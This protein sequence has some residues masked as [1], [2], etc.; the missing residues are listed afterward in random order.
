MRKKIIALTMACVL[1]SSLAACG[2]ST[3]TT[4]AKE[5]STTASTVTS[6]SGETQKEDTENNKDITII[7][8]TKCTGEAW[9]DSMSIGEQELAKEL[10]IEVYQMAPTQYDS[11]A[12]VSVLQDAIAQNPTAICINPISSEAVEPYLEQAMEAGIT[13][14]AHEGEDL[15]N[16]DFDLEEMS[17]KEYGAHFMDALAEHM[18]ETGDY[19]IIVGSLT[20]NAHMVRAEAA[21]ERQKEAYPNMNLVTDIAEPSEASA[22]GEY[23]LTKELLTAYPTLKGLFSLENPQALALAVEEAGKAGEITVVGVGLPSQSRDYIENGSLQFI[24]YP[25]PVDL[26]YAWA[27]LAYD[28]ATGEEIS[29]GYDLGVE[30]YNSLQVDEKIIR[31]SG[32]VDA[33]IDNIDQHNEA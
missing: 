9:F 14:I 2:G 30:G 5:E 25:N 13:V 22:N 21:V 8:I 26:G 20:N 10:G 19:A 28:V 24:C 16:I 27:K 23:N 33:D 3:D 7:T 18:G 17:N 4:S 6:S 1:G 31:G 11:A 12:Q 32:W 15:Q 29:T